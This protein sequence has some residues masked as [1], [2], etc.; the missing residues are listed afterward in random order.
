MSF[1][2]EV[3]T[4]IKCTDGIAAYYL[5]E[6]DKVICH[7][8]EKVYNGTISW[9]GVHKE[10]PDSSPQQ[11]ICIDTWKSRTS[12]SRDMVN[13]K[14]IT[15]IDK[16]PFYDNE[17]PF[18]SEQDYIDRFIKNG[19]SR[20]QAKAV[21]NRM[22]DTL[23]F[24]NVPYMNATNYAIEAVRQV[25]SSNQNNNK[26]II[27][28]IAKQCVEEAQ[29]EYF[30]LVD[31]YQKVIEQCDRDAACLTDTLDIV[32]KCWNEL[33]KQKADRTEKISVN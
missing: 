1:N 24:Y 30:E 21:C 27:N 22:S 33:E 3:G 19:Y 25:N 26:D 15:Y 2:I 5:Y 31:I 28:K 11:V 32:S 8:R 29:K 9:I 20:E 14:D 16:N 18:G 13:V 12:M 10:N 17:R 4:N 7:T 23:M 6:G